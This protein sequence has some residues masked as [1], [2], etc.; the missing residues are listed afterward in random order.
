MIKSY[1]KATVRSRKTIRIV[2][3]SLISV[4][5]VMTLLRVGLEV[6]GQAILPVKTVKI[7]GNRFIKNQEIMSMLHLNSGTSLIFLNL[8]EAKDNL[9]GD[10]RIKVVQ[11]VKVYPDTLRVHIWEK[12][13][14]AILGRNDMR[15]LVSNDGVVL[16]QAVQDQSYSD[17]PFI[18]LLS[19][20]DDI[21]IG[22]PVDNFLVLNLLDAAI[23][24]QKQ[25]PE[26]AATIGSYVIADS[27]I[28]VRMNEPRYRIFFGSEVDAGKLNRLRALI[29]VLSQSYGDESEE[30]GM[31]EIDM[32]GSHAAVREGD[33]DEL[34]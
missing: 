13:P 15:Y 33:E 18:S 26:F 5:A 9:K 29:L 6:T 23:E 16:A 17:Y 1:D 3:I 10:D 28:W 25:H 24:F 2:L 4:L 32:S 31:V 8:E 22:N 14:V 11:M 27:G 7:F 20:D 21:K 19:K 12:E 30:P 34:R